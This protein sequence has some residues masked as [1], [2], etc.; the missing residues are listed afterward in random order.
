MTTK[1]NVHILHADKALAAKSRQ[2]AARKRAERIESLV[3]V[4][5]V[6]L[7][8][9]VVRKRAVESWQDRQND[10]GHYSALAAGAD[11]ATIDRWTVNYIRDH[12]CAYDEELEGDAG[13]TRVSDAATRIR[14]KVYSEIARAYP[15]L[16]DECRR[17]ASDRGA[18]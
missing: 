2:G 14:R 1:A 18:I 5:G 16:A 10:R 8:L 7:P 13:K 3:V 12:L 17:Q 15:D 11:E 9:D 4:V 6:V